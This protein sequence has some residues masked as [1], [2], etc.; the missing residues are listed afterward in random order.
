MPVPYQWLRNSRVNPKLS[1]H[2]YL[3]GNFNFNAT[4][5][6]S[7]G[8]K[9]AIH[10]KSSQRSSWSYHA[11][12]GF[13]VGPSMHHYRCMRCYLPDT[14]TEI[15]SDTLQFI[16]TSVPVPETTTENDLQQAVSD[17]LAILQ[18]PPKALPF[19]QAGNITLD[20]IKAIAVL[21]K[22]ATSQPSPTLPKQ[23]SS[24]PPSL[25]SLL[26][27]DPNQHPLQRVKLEKKVERFPSE[28]INSLTQQY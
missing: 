2:A 9:I 22:R 21:L 5:L 26:P 23:L 7:L 17:I 10:K 14:R 11:T 1:T 6:A 18:N 15:D 24:I 13:Y 25:S 27:S 12:E 4:P 19:L 8:I 20:A 28:K 16:P 3:F